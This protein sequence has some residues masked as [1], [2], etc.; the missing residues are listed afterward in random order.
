MGNSEKITAILYK[1][2]SIHELVRKMEAL[3]SG[4]DKG[5]GNGKDKGNGN[6]GD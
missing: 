4:K 1:L 2:I 5:N 3:L 6:G